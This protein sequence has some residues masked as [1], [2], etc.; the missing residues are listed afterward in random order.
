MWPPI[1]VIPHVE[2]TGEQIDACCRCIWNEVDEHHIQGDAFVRLVFA[3]VRM[4]DEAC[5]H[6]TDESTHVDPHPV[7]VD[8]NDD[9][10]WLTTEILQP[11]VTEYAQE[12]LSDDRKALEES[13]P[14]WLHGHDEAAEWYRAGARK[15]IAYYE[16]LIGGTAA[17]VV[18]L[19]DKAVA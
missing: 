1:A 9:V 6:P 2:L 13:L 3:S 14:Q 7:I 19:P 11:F 4:F 17:L 8:I 12:G 18:A 15:R 16:A 10:V 5:W